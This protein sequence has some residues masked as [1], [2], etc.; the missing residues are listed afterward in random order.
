VP[1]FVRS[2]TIKAPV[3]VVFGLHERDDALEL[4]TPPFPPVHVVEKSGGIQSGAR[5]VLRVG[6]VLRWVALHTVYERNRLFVDEQIEG[7]FALWVHRH[8]FEALPGQTRLTDR[9]TYRLPGGALVNRL[10]EPAA[11]LGLARMFSYRHA[12]TRR[13]CEEVDR[14]RR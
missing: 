13:L 9:V 4:L 8:E 7:P 3:D 2:V 5:V 11:A 10:A 12:V 14:S 6:L 1:E